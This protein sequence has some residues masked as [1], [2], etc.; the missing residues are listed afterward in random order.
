MPTSHVDSCL[1]AADEVA[2][3]RRGQCG[4]PS[5]ILG[6]EDPPEELYLRGSLPEEGPVVA[7]VGARR[8][9]PT[10]KRFAHMLSF[11]L[12]RRG[13]V[14]V[15]GG[16]VGIDTAAHEGALDG[17]GIT[18]AVLGSG[19]DNP[20]PQG[21]HELFRAISKR[22]ALLTEFAPPQPPQPWT[23]PKRNRI[24]AALSDVIVVV[25][26]S[27]NSGALITAK[28]ARQ[29]GIPV[30]AAPG[31]AGDPAHRGSHDL[32][33][34]GAKLVESAKEVLEIVGT[35]PAFEQLSLPRLPIEV[36]KTLPSS[37]AGLS[38]AET[39][40]LGSLGARCL[41]ID[42]IAAGTGL[43]PAQT[44]AVVLGLEVAGLIEDQGGRR[45]VRVG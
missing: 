37:S 20:Y 19:F 32:I 42:E 24:V 45:F 17:G 15:S 2:V 31:P 30:A 7:I 8:A 18:I 16:A 21:N 14:V 28:H 25:Q 11:E 3:L 22:G 9:D 29:L 38:A 44:S 34:A 26:A 12:A 10:S 1:C 5:R 39:K 33:R 40:V 13:A 6:L 41:H 36:K 35:R 43:G 27:A 4:Y 23:F